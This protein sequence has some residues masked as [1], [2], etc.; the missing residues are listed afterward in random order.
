VGPSNK[1]VRFND[2]PEIKSFDALLDYYDESVVEDS[3]DDNGE[4]HT[5][6]KCSQNPHPVTIMMLSTVRNSRVVSKVLIDQCCTGNG[7]ISYDLATR[8]S[9]AQPRGHS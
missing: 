9:N 3:D 5:T 4:V 2:L 8:A 6:E 1:K 7:I